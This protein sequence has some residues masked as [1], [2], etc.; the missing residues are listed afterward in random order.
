M[1]VLGTVLGT[2]AMWF[3]RDRVLSLGNGD[4]D[5]QLSYTGMQALVMFAVKGFHWVAV[6]CV[7]RR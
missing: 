3:M 2:G 6:S 4:P 1:G 5:W 7:C